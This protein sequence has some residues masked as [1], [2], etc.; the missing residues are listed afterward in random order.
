MHRAGELAQFA[1]EAKDANVAAWFRRKI[2]SGEI[3]LEEIK[4]AMLYDSAQMKLWV[5]EAHPGARS[6]Y[7]FDSFNQ[8]RY[9]AGDVVQRQKTLLAMI[10]TDP[11]DERTP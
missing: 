9:T 10:S 11:L 2:A 7:H 8:K 5:Q 6:W 3:T 4:D 1:T